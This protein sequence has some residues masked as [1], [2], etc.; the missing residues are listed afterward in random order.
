MA[1]STG[2]LALV[3]VMTSP[4]GAQEASTPPIYSE[5]RLTLEVADVD[6]DT[7]P[8]GTPAAFEAAFGQ[9]P[10]N[11]AVR[12]IDGSTFT[13]VPLALIPLA[14]E[15]VALV[16]TGRSACTGHPCSG[17]NAVHYLREVRA[18]YE[19]EGEWS[20]VGATGTFGHPAL[21]W[22]WSDAIA[23]DP[24]LYTE[25]GGVWQG[26]ACSRASLTA[27]TPAG[28]LEIASIPVFFSNEGAMGEGDTSLEGT[29]TSVE[30]GRSFTVTYRGSRTFRE[31]YVRGEDGHYE[32]RGGTKVP[33][34]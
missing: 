31:H 16:S 28:P 26:Y 9:A 19:V 5:K 15:K 6:R 8:P 2:A 33:S 12:E 24:V 3:A 30:K 7:V 22:G 17:I 11:E 18:R 4:A 27:L 1:R 34:C 25:G 32:V 29:I 14:G 10:R 20:H 13:F 21:R 23:D